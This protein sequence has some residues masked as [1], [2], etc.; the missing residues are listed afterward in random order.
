M[1][2]LLHLVQIAHQARR[3]IRAQ[4]N[5]AFERRDM[6]HVISPHITARVA[7]AANAVATQRCPFFRTVFRDL[8]LR[9]RAQPESE[10]ADLKA[11]GSKAIAEP[12]PGEGSNQ[13]KHDAEQSDAYTSP[14]RDRCENPELQDRKQEESAREKTRP[15]RLF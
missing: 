13:K 4:K 8:G 1:R 6:H 2:I 14:S 15:V 5:F 12:A 10:R 3:I 11:R 7:H 9:N